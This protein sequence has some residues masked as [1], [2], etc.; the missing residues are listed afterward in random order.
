MAE[1]EYRIQA[2]DG[3]ILRIVGPDDATP[4]QLRAAAERA[5]AVR[6]QA[7]AP[8]AAAPQ[9]EAAPPVV[10]PA[11]AAPSVEAPQVAAVPPQPAAM[12]TAPAAMPAAPQR[13]AAPPQAAMQ[14][15]A[16][17]VL[18]SAPEAPVQPQPPAAP[19]TYEQT[20]GIPET[21]LPGMAGAV[22]RGAA[23]P[24][25]GAALGGAV[26]GPVGA[27]IGAGGAALAPVVLDPAVRAFNQVF[28]TNVSTP[29]QALE[30]FMTRMGVAVPR[31]EAERATQD[32]TR[33]VTTGIAGPA[34][35]ARAVQAV[36]P[37]GSVAARTAEAMRVGG[38]GPTGGAGMTGVTGAGVRTG[39]AATAGGIG[40]LAAEGSPEGAIGGALFGSVMPAVG[41][42]AKLV[43]NLWNSTIGP[44]TK[45]TQT[46]EDVLFNALG[47]TTETGRAAQA[48]FARGGQAAAAPGMQRNLL[49]I[50]DAGNVEPTVDLAAL[51][52]R[53]ARAGSPISDQVLQFQRQQVSALRQSLLQVNDQLR[54]PM[55]TPARRSELEGVRDTMLARVDAEEAILNAAARAKGEALPG[56]QA[57][58]QAIATR[59]EELSK[60]LRETLIRPSYKAAL[61]SAGNAKS[62]IDGLVADAERILGRPLSD[63]APDTAPP[64]VR[65]IVALR[66]APDE[67]PRILGPDGKPLPRPT[68]ATLAELDDLRKAIN[69]TI[70]DA[71]RGS[72]ALS[73]VEVNQLQGLHASVD[74]MVRESPA[75][76]AETKQLY[77][78]ALSNYRD[79]YAPRFREGETARILKP[80][81]FGEM[82]VD[83]SQVVGSYLKDQDAA[84]Q[85][86]RTFA[87]DATAFSAMRDGLVALARK[88]AMSN[89]QFDPKKL[90]GW[91]QTNA[92]VLR[93][94][95]D[96]GMNVRGALQQVEQGAL[97]AKAALDNLATFRGPFQGKTADQMLTYITAD[98]ARMKLALERSN[99]QG[100]DAIRRVTAESLNQLIETNPSAA[101]KAL[102]DEAQRRAYLVAL[103][104][105]IV[106]GRNLINEF[107]ERARLGVAARQALAD[108]TLAQPGAADQVIR[109]SNLS[110]P[111]LQ[112]LLKLAQDDIARIKRIDETATRGGAAP[113]I[114]ALTK[115]ASDAGVPAL[116][117]PSS[118]MSAVTQTILRALNSVDQAVNRKVNAELARVIYQNPEAAMLA[119]ENAIQRAQR[120]QRPAPVMRAAPA[121]AGTLGGA[122]AEEFTRQR[123][124]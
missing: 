120:A 67:G 97:Q 28:G 78:K 106:P 121:A 119:I 16:V 53:L 21:T 95:E 4:D 117:I 22:T 40:G 114:G 64:I 23:L 17:E 48:G 13:A 91:L 24:L 3:S 62:N 57:A 9:P 18:A 12:P 26:A 87:G 61:D 118:S 82:R 111:A 52:S 2:P 7:A 43:G 8:A 49:E 34:G 30:N 27:A 6:Q 58:G 108:P 29:S 65:R 74:R 42:G 122:A 73:G 101:L 94:F 70:A 100:K 45:P 88:E 37:A 71:R 68:R 46:A 36:A 83:P 20:F 85:F 77:D 32:I 123:Q 112:G 35:V 59:A 109:R 110:L 14:A 75:F 124:D 80:A 15:P 60:G 105:N 5:F 113:R 1:R 99:E 98:P 90:Q 38:M 54:V 89:F 39:A 102:T 76:S 19:M 104:E 10:A 11:A 63:F 116:T 96:A 81:M 66:N 56:P 55:L 115:E 25:A 47:G 93:R 103:P 33:G 41:A 86:I 84:D 51:T 50:L 44:I 72:T 107:T 69:G 79:I 31:S 92:P